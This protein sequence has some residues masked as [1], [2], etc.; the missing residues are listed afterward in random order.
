MGMKSM[1]LSF[2]PAL[3]CVVCKQPATAGRIYTVNPLVWQLVPL[4]NEH[5]EELPGS[6]EPV[7]ISALQYRISEQ[8]TVVRQLQRRRR[9]IARAYVRL[10]REHAHIKAQRALR[11]RLNQT[12]KLQAEAMEVVI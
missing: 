8:L 3:P 7:A 1:P 6:D 10:R 4:C 9:R 11:W 2:S 5:T 12:Y